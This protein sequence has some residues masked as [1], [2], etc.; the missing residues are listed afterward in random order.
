MPPPMSPAILDHLGADKFV[1]AGW[2]GGGPHALACAA[3]LPDRCL[4][5]ATIAGVAPHDAAGL[6]WLDGMA[7]EN[8]D[9]FALAGQGEA[10]LSELPEPSSPP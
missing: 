2:S 10:K 5:A 1:T 9:E 3:L 8:L 6:D 7:Q 4:A